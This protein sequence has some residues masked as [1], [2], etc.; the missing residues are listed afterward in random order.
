MTFLGLN[1][2]ISVLMPSS[3]DPYS[4]V[5]EQPLTPSLSLKGRGEGEG[6]ISFKRI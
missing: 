3:L 4:I 1:L 2:L 6:N 5:K